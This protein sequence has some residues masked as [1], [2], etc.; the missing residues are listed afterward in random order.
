MGAIARRLEPAFAAINAMT[1]PLRIQ[2]VRCMA[3]E[4]PCASMFMFTLLDIIAGR[5][6]TRINMRVRGNFR[7]GEPLPT[8]E[9]T[10]T[11]YPWYPRAVLPAPRTCPSSFASESISRTFPDT[12]QRHG[13]FVGLA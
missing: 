2:P 5:L 11:F 7:L 8:Q 6:Q 9:C 12:R 3:C 1:I 10:T 4:L 13:G